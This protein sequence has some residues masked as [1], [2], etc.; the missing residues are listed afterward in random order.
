ML[1]KRGRGDS[2]SD[3]GSLTHIE[4]MVR[5]Y[6]TDYGN[7]V[8]FSRYNQ[9]LLLKTFCAHWVE[10]ALVMETEKLKHLHLHPPSNNLD[11]VIL[12]TM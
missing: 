3:N 1:A 2:S 6:I 10:T 8:R 12:V 7:V 9:T 11:H 5:A 4:A